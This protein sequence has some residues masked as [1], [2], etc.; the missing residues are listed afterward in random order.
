MG[1][2][3]PNLFLNGSIDDN[4]LKHRALKQQLQLLAF[5]GSSSLFIHLK[6]PFQAV[7]DLREKGQH[8]ALVTEQK[9]EQSNIFAKNG[10]QI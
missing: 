6:I 3:A 4:V 7:R 8:F 9:P 5:G 2:Y 10:T 1:N